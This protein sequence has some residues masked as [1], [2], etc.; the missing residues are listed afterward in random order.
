MRAAWIVAIVLLSPGVAVAQSTQSPQTPQSQEKPAGSTFTAGWR[1]GFFIQNDNGD[2]RLQI[3]LFLQADNRFALED[4]SETLTDTFSIRRFR[5]YLR[6]RVAQR[7]E[8]FVN[9]DFAGGVLTVYDAY[10]DTRFSNA[11][12]LRVGK[13]KVPVGH[14]RAQAAA[15]QLLFERGFPTAISPNRDV[16]VLVLGDVRGGIVSYQAGV[17]NGTADGASGDTD[18]NDGKDAVGR[19]I[20]R[21]FVKQAKSPLAGVSL[22]FSASAGKQS[23]TTPL[24]AFRTSTM[25]QTFFAYTGATA[26]GTRTR[27]SPFASYYNKAF[28]GFVE[29]VRSEMPIRK[30]AI[31]EDIAHQA[32][33]IAGSYVLTGEAA[34]DA[35]IKPKANFDFGG[36]HWGAFQVA[37]RYHALS[38]DEAAIRLGFAVAGASREAKAWTAGLNWYW[39]P[40]I[41][42]TFNFERVVFDGDAN[43]PRK[44]EN[45]LALRTQLYF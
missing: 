14:E 16:G 37:A 6:G 5:P 4:S 28:G 8:F 26:D 44:P 13:G 29:Y 34:S 7:F 3:G 24:P 36:G 45:I 2:F 10:L 20:V 39:N 35:G 42:Y 32:W 33:Q 15:T 30:G 12:R 9:P 21:P 43:G 19:L 31:V 17:V 11:F 38:V 27:Y 22:A 23:G 41:R 40:Y 25:Q 18:T 1:D